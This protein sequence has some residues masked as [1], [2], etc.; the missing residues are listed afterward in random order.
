M[1]Y[2][3]NVLLK[4][5]WRAI[6]STILQTSC[7]LSESINIG[8]KSTMSKVGSCGMLKTMNEILVIRQ[9]GVHLWTNSACKVDYSVAK[10][11]VKQGH[12]QGVLASRFRDGMWGGGGPH[13][14][15]S[16]FCNR[17]LCSSMCFTMQKNTF[18]HP[19]LSTIKQERNS[20]Q[21][22]TKYAQHF[23]L[24]GC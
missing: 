23:S 12:E 4:S 5:E 13:A 17:D 9:G 3:L 22:K 15:L 18:S 24:S 7:L 14:T 10:L 8:Y 20:T 6:W 21:R 2:V 11:S 1:I 19:N 16:G